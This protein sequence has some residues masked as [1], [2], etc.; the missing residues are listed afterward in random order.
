MP[1][2]QR[3]YP[4]VVIE[5][6]RVRRTIAFLFSC[7]FPLYP[8][9]VDITLFL[10]LFLFLRLACNIRVTLMQA[11]LHCMKPQQCYGSNLCQDATSR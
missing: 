4:E 8:F 5:Q 11:D 7:P 6:S 2:K 9:L 1:Y 3:I 10:S